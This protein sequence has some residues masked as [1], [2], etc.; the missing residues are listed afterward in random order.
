MRRARAPYDT[1]EIGVPPP[2]PACFGEC[3]RV[4]RRAVADVRAVAPRSRS[5]DDIAAR[6]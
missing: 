1:A 4:E 5:H 3:K 2:I 6:P